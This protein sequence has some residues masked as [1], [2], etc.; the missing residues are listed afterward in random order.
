[1]KSRIFYVTTVNQ[2]SKKQQRSSVVGFISLFGWE[3]DKRAIEKAVA[4]YP[5]QDNWSVHESKFR[6]GK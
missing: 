4:K 5:N 3:S 2:F 6:R 1:M